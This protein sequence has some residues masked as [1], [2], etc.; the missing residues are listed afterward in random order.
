MNNISIVLPTYNES[1]NILSMIETLFRVAK[2]NK[3]NLRILVVDDNSPDGTAHIVTEIAKTNTQ[4]S[5]LLGEKEGLGKAYIRGF[6][7]VLKTHKPEIIVMMDCD[8]S[9]S[10]EHLPALI[11]S[12]LVGNDYVIG[13]RYIDGGAIPGDWPIKRILNSKIANLVAT[14]LG[15]ITPSIKDK[16]GGFKA[17]RASALKK[18]E[19]EKINT[20]GYGFQMHLLGLFI[21]GGYRIHEVPIIFRDREFGKSKMKTSDILGF[22]KCAYSLNPDSPVRQILRFGGVGISGVLVNL[23]MLYILK[24]GTAL[25]IVLDSAIAIQVSIVT[26]FILHSSFTFSERNQKIELN[27]DHNNLFG[28]Y[29]MKQFIK[30]N[31]MALGVSIVTLVIFALFHQLFNVY[32]LL[33]QSIA[34]VASFY[35]NY[36]ISKKYIWTYSEFA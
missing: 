25:N 23:T 21:N 6:S 30:F 31:I 14:L 11:N 1:E 35:L 10:P 7:E 16:S 36:S 27:S 29:R 3:Y 26:N 22:I 5:L 18:V 8:F 19:Y 2:K 20:F 4:V 34:I 24:N 12:I 28:I 15:G 33:A 17:I 13:S 9:H 32:Y